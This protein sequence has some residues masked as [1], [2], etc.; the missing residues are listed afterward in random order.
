MR[1]LKAALGLIFLLAASARLEA[2]GSLPL[3]T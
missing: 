3:M 1:T 2:G